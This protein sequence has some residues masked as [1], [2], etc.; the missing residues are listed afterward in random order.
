MKT[1]NMRLLALILAAFLLLT[2]CT[3]AE[4]GEYAE[5]VQSALAGDSDVIPFAD[6]EYE[7]PDMTRI[8]ETLDA[9]ITASQSDSSTVEAVADAIYRFYDEYDWFFTCSALADIHYSA[10]LTDIYWEKEYNYCTENGTAVDAMLEELYY[11]LALSPHREALEGEDYFGEGYFDSYEGDNPWDETFVALMEEESELI[12]RYYSLSSQALEYEPDSDEYFDAVADDMA[13]LL[14]ELIVKRQEIAAYWGYPDYVEFASDFYYYRDFTPAEMA[15]YLE[16]VHSSLVPVYE[17]IDSEDWAAAYDYSDEADTF[18]YVRTAAQNMGGTVAEAFRLL[19]RGKLYDI[20]YGEN[21]YAS[22]FE[23]Y[24]T[25]YWEP[26]IFMN[27]G[28]SRYDWL[29]FAHEFGHFCNDYASYGSY[30]GTDVLEVFSQGMEYLSLCYGEPTDDLIRM[31]MADSLSV[32]VEQSA[33]AAFE[34]QMYALP[35][36]ELTVEGLYA[37]YDKIA[38]EYG[39]ESVGYDP[40]EFVTIPHFYTNPLYV[41]S[42]VVSNDA[43]MQLYQLEQENPGAGLERFQENLDTQ[44]T[45]FL[46]FLDAAGL[47][48]PLAPGRMEKVRE[49]FEGFFG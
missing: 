8:R 18:N 13:Q 42:Y 35:A 10:D 7:R 14:V 30:A 40:R 21:K 23:I 36:Q 11:S 27:P 26:F 16:S 43:A 41:I 28:M 1:K 37:L 3:P 29:T 6:M 33:F 15:D 9:A 48:N 19:E 22:S 12:N 44:E 5:A 24:L 47:E 39:F 38:Q 4:L 25:S 31:K 49:T 34:Q 20:G 45:Y 32:Y 17:K 2:G 46:A